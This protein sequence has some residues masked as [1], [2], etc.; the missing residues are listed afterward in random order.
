MVIIVVNLL[1]GRI[2]SFRS[3]MN[4]QHILVPKKHVSGEQSSF[5]FHSFCFNLK[6]QLISV[7]L[8]P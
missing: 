4:E 2:R 6:N 1:Y 5:F 3:R 8:L 7:L